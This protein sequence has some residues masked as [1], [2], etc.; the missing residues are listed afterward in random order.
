M[1]M[2]TVRAAQRSDFVLLR[3]IFDDWHPGVVSIHEEPRGWMVADVDGVVG[4]GLLGREFCN[5]DSG[6][7][8]Y[9]H[10]TEDD[11]V[12]FAALMCVAPHLRG[13]GIGTKLMTHWIESTPSWAHVVMPDAS[14]DDPTRV[15]RS[16]FFERLGFE[17][18][19]TAHAQIEPW[20]MIR[21]STD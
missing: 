13:D 9:G 17:W 12:P 20:L 18:M 6:L 7:L 16:H 10:L 8:G 15:A 2:A 3:R 14:D 21:Q 1:H 19:P 4:G 5:W 11:V